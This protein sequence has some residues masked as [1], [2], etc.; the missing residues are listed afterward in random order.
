MSQ[1]VLTSLAVGYGINYGVPYLM[2]YATEKVAS[3][4]LNKTTTAVKNKV[5]NVLY[6]SKELEVEYEMINVDSEGNVIHEPIMYVT[7]KKNSLIDQSWS[8]ISQSVQS[9][10]TTPSPPP[11]V[12]IHSQIPKKR[13]LS[14]EREYHLPR[15]VYLTHEDTMN[16]L[17]NDLMDLD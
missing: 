17:L 6:K 11:P 7:S 13:E 5:N 10:G 15:E 9:I 3:V 16:I 8:D 14:K 4:I 1:F 12:A 2:R